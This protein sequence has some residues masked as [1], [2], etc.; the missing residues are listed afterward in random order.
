M[1]PNVSIVIRKIGEKNGYDVYLRNF[2]ATVRD[3]LEALNDAILRM[4]LHRSRQDGHHCHGCDLCC[5][6]RAPLTSIDCLYL[7]ETLDEKDLDGFFNRY[8]NIF[9]SGQAVD[10]TLKRDE[11]LKCAF[12]DQQDKSCSVYRTRP[13]V[14]QSFICAPATPRARQLR[15]RIVN[16]G[17]DELVRLWFK[18][19]MIMHIADDPRP[20]PGDWPPTAFSGKSDFGSVLLR[21]ILPPKL[22]RAMKWPQEK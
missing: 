22:W 7:M 12:L 14:C 6:E 15:E 16:A 2:R 10:I 1:N 13:L 8:A 9:V 3:Y 17:E 5:A 4:P 18:T 19:S 20:D 21:D 11:N